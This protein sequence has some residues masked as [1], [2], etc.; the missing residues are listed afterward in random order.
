MAKGQTY[1]HE[2]IRRTDPVTGLEMLQ[3]TS[4]TTMSEHFTYSGRS[5]TGGFTADSDTI[6][7]R[8]MRDGGRDAPWDIFRV[9]V[10]GANLTQLTERDDIGGYVVSG[11]D[12]TIYYM[13]HGTLFS[14]NIDTFVEEEVAHIDIGVGEW[15]GAVRRGEAYLWALLSPDGRW[16]LCPTF[17]AQNRIAL[18]RCATD[19]SDATFTHVGQDCTYHTID[20][21]GRGVRMFIPD[22][23]GRRLILADFNGNTVARYGTTPLA[24]QAPLGTS[25]LHQGCAVLP[26]RAI[27]TMAEG[28]EEA[29]PLVE[30]PYFWH[31]SGS[32]DGDWIVADTNWPNEGIQLICVKTRRFGTLLHAHNSAGHPQWTHLHPFFSPDC[33]HVA[34]GSD[35][36]GTPQ[37]YVAKVPQGLSEELARG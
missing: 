5:M 8:S 12:Q 35:W 20:P 19:G 25:G 23:E 21:L 27:L 4:F 26:T 3:L 14:M 15:G 28:D 13:E 36:S 16:Y 18:L 24:H 32:I 2:R 1:N 11:G 9:D 6:V 31:S 7:F 34:F 30:G 22:G 33:R 37:V 10:D 17:D 29:V